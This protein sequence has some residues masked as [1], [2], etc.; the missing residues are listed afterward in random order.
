MLDYH[1]DYHKKRCRNVGA[2]RIAYKRL[3]ALILTGRRRRMYHSI[4]SSNLVRPLNSPFIQF[5]GLVNGLAE[6]AQGID[7]KSNITQPGRLLENV[8]SA[9]GLS[10]CRDK[11]HYT[12][13]RQRMWVASAAR[14]MLW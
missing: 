4:Q 6:K 11:Y 14:L 10:R 5:E 3:R 2:L 1:Q 7:R 13:I 9:D 12:T 8:I